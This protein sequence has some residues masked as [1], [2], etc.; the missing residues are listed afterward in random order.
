MNEYFNKNL[1]MTEEE[2]LFQKSNDC[3]ICKKFISSD[4][5]KVRDHCHVTGKFR[6]TAHESCN[7]NFQLTNKVPVIFH[8]LRSYDS[9]F[10][11]NE[12][13]KF[14]VKIKVI[15]NGLEKYMAFFFNKNLV[16]I[17]SMQFMS[18]S[19][20][21]LVKNLSDKDFKY[22]IEEFGFENLEL[23]KQKGVYPY[24]YMNSFERFN[25]KKL[26]AKKYF[27]NSIKDGKIDE[28]GKISDGQIDVNDYLTCKKTWNKFEMKNM[29][30]YH[31]HYLKKDVLLLADVFEKFIDTCLKYY[32]LDPCHYF[33]APGLSW[34]AMLKMTGIELE[35]IPDIDKYLFT[36]KGLRGRISY[37]AKKHSKANNKYLNDYDPKKPSTFIS[38]IDMNNLWLANESISSLWEI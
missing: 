29:G 26:P 11:F 19:L 36:E 38:Y 27:Y 34:D 4:E 6:G 33:S 24:E 30:D 9:H 16:F 31:D 35:K 12:L 15:P 2:N 3:W 10:I 22:L 1:I 7:L 5:D 17:D 37:I 21:K 13:D 32:G 25:E 23:L 28:D 8:N 20:D 18:S 14:D